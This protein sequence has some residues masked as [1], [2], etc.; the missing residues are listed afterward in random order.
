MSRR[1]SLRDNYLAQ[2]DRPDLLQLK[3]N[4]VIFPGSKLLSSIKLSDL[5]WDFTQLST[6]TR[7]HIRIDFSKIADLQSPLGKEIIWQSQKILSVLIFRKNNRN[8]LSGNFIKPSTMTTFFQNVRSIAKHAQEHNISVYE[9]LESKEHLITYLN[10]NRNNSKTKGLTQIFSKLSNLPAKHLD[11]APQFEMNEYALLLLKNSS[12]QSRQH[13]IIPTNILYSKIE[14][15]RSR[16]KEYMQYNSQ[17]RAYIHMACTDPSYGRTSATQR[18]KGLTAE[19]GWN[20]FFAESI[21]EHGLDTLSEKYAWTSYTNIV[22]YCTQVQHAA[23]MLVHVFTAMRSEEAYSLRTGCVEHLPGVNNQAVTVIGI[24]TKMEDLPKEESWV[25]IPAI[26]EYIEAAE[27]LAHTIGAFLPQEYENTN[28]TRNP[29][30]F[31]STKYL[32]RP[33]CSIKIRGNEIATTH[34][35][36]TC[37]KFFLAPAIT[38]EDINELKFFEP[39]IDWE[40]EESIRAGKLWNVTTH[41]IRRSIAFYAAQSG[42]VSLH[43]LRKLLKH[44]NKVTTLYYSNGAYVGE[45]IFRQLNPE[46]VNFFKTERNHAS[47]VAYV[48]LILSNVSPL[49]GGHG[50]WVEANAKLDVKDVTR[51]SDSVLSTK[52]LIDIGLF[53]YKETA[54]G[55]C[56]SILPCNQRAHGEFW[57][58]VSCSKAAIIE[59]KLFR[60]IEQQE[61]LLTLLTEGSVE[62]NTELGYLLELKSLIKSK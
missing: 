27:H 6:K 35:S 31:I 8:N 54:L 37:E 11:V 13:F 20:T 60:T 7:G 30:L 45:L 59:P 43:T 49:L 48:K 4:S 42:L 14:V 58:C 39:L 17:I 62:Y 23:K 1:A 5:V 51:M 22:R 18:R 3:P 53:S 29:L 28:E 36:G 55:G 52:K 26:K 25:T 33:F 57:Q 16:L 32:L 19:L 40:A 41:Q 47:A 46:I 44:L 12:D 10:H 50:G 56:T 2:D 61:K 21:T 9:L 38:E 24:T 34:L 15:Y